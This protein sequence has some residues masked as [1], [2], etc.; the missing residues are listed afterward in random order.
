VHP[1]YRAGPPPAPVTAPGAGRPPGRSGRWPRSGPRP[2]RRRRPHARA[3][4]ASRSSGWR[5]D[6]DRRARL[7]P[8][9]SVACVLF[10]LSR[11]D[12][13]SPPAAA[14]RAGAEAA[15]RRGLVRYG[16][17]R[18][19]D[20][21]SSRSRPPVEHLARRYAGRGEPLEDLI[22]AGSL[23]LVKAIDR[24][25]PAPRAGLQHVR[26]AD[27]RRGD[28]PALPG[29]HLG[30][31][32]PPRSAGTHRGGGAERPRAHPGARPRPERPRARGQDGSA[33]PVQEPAPSTLEPASWTRC[34]PRHTTLRPYGAPARRPGAAVVPLRR[35]VP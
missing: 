6:R 33:G 23:G 29:P 25:D 11:V 20:R 34:R 21:A 10:P 35:P 14:G 13:R 7:S 31:A 8:T 18:Y 22:Q 3:R 32:R 19:R 9:I 27:R 5:A 4:P 28:P 17:A 2:G 30:R 16:S 12:G 24:Y 15:G 26:R 1:G